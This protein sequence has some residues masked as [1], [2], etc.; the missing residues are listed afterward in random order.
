MERRD[1]ERREEDREERKGVERRRG[2][3][4]SV[5]TTALPACGDSVEGNQL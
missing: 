5:L 3:E 2:E 1:E 4:R